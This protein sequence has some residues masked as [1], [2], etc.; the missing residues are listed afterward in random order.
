MGVME[1]AREGLSGDS[2]FISKPYLVSTRVPMGIT[3]CRYEPNGTQ[4]Y[5]NPRWVITVVPWS[6][7]GSLPELEPN[8]PGKVSMNAGATRDQ[9][10][11]KLVEMLNRQ[12]TALGPV[13]MVQ[14][15]SPKGQAFYSFEDYTDPIPS[16][17]SGIMAP[18]VG[19]P[20]P[21][22][23]PQPQ[24][25]PQP[26]SPAPQPQAQP[27]VPPQFQQANPPQPQPAGPQ[28]T[29]TL[30]HPECGQSVTGVPEFV[31]AVNRYGIAHTC[32]QLGPC[33]VWF[34]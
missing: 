29:A 25:Q 1:Q 18:P 31:A 9:M 5:P 22:P 21:F 10:F 7:G 2:K 27:P 14:V 32:P 4:K 13:M 20:L 15:K 19:P 6:G 17:Y 33:Y 26:P 12:S 34:G 23:Q 11:Q 28:Q 3:G 30:P 24:Y 16:G 8:E